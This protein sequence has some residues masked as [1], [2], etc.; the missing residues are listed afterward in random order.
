MM[1]YPG[2]NFTLKRSYTVYCQSAFCYMT[3][4]SDEM[5]SDWQ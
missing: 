4:S 5:I 2:V 3:E 1:Q